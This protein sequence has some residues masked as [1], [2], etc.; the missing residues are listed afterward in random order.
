MAAAVRLICL[1]GTLQPPV[2]QRGYVASSC[3]GGDAS[4]CSMPR[5]ENRRN[6]T[7]ATPRFCPLQCPAARTSPRRGNSDISACVSASAPIQRRAHT[8]SVMAATPFQSVWCGPI[9][10]ANR[11]NGTTT[12]AHVRNLSRRIRSF[13]PSPAGGVNVT[14]LLFDPSTSLIPCS[15]F[16]RVAPL[17]R[18]CQNQRRPYTLLLSQ[19]FR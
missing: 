1:H 11:L 8:L 15:T 14:C 10:A 5:G 17:A 4:S 3:S 9:G 16:A 18:Q 2:R 19:R 6:S 12:S 7:V 13:C